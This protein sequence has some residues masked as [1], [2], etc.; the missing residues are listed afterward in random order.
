[1]SGIAIKE[2]AKTSIELGESHFREFKSGMEGRP[3]DKR[4]RNTKD[5]STNIAQTLVAFANADG[6]ELLVGVE[7]NGTISGLNSFKEEE[8][9]LLEE[10]IITRIH[11]DTPLPT[12]KKFRLNL[13]GFVVLYF[14]VPKS[15]KYVHVTSDGRCL[16]R[17]DLESVPVSS[18]AI[19]F[20]RN[21]ELSR[22]YDR[23]FIDGVSAEALDL[24]LVKVV[25]D[26]ILKGMSPEK[27]L[28][29]LELAEYGMSQLRLRKAALLLFAKEPTKWHPRVQIRIIK[30]EGNELKTGEEYNVISDESVTGNILTLVDKSW[31]KLR[32]HLVHTTFD[33]SARFTQKSI[34]PELACKEALLNSIA[35]RDYSDE[36][37]GIEVYIYK[38]HL[39]IKNPGSLLSSIKIQD[40]I[41]QSGAH[42]SRNTY[43]ARVLRELGYMRELGEGMRRIYALMHKN[44][45]AAPLLTS[46]SDGFSITLTHKPIYSEKDLLWLSQFDG[47][48]LDREQK[49]VILLGQEERV[50]SPQDIWEAVGIVDTEH[51]RS[52]VASLFKIRVLGNKVAK[53]R[54]KRLAKNEHIPFRQYPRYEIRIPDSKINEE[55]NIYLTV[56]DEDVR[57]PAC[58]IFVTPI[59]LTATDEEIYSALSKHGD[60]AELVVPRSNKNTKGYC[61]VEYADS[62][63]MEKAIS[64]HNHIRLQ[65]RVLKFVMANKK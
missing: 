37:R 16:Q 32:P 11:R 17:S 47:F 61:F 30:V 7:D 49:S 25:S 3:D 19:Q 59:P 21:E 53:D 50:F 34:Y 10:S 1:M 54:A 46:T 63:S 33:S 55:T 4:K 27:C 31:E 38:D 60:V 41:N 8:L 56:D 52:L 15:T 39:E 45:L 58:S 9:Q 2:R 40:I 18:E 51:Y 23:Q 20:N 5:I 42:Q 43:I 28:Q 65:D 64:S 6:G 62:T 24:D 14:S 57:K 35:H 44:E 26:Q 36:G 12:V 22:E 13:D 48:D 29:Y